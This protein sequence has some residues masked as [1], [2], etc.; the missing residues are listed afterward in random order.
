MSIF[1]IV[2]GQKPLADRSIPPHSGAQPAPHQDQP[3]STDKANPLNG[4]DSGDLIDFGQNEATAHQAPA[5]TPD[6]IE[7]MLKSTG[8]PAD[9][10]LMHFE[11]DMKRS[12]PRGGS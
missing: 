11:Q 4:E 10:P 12:L 8:K 3:S 5:K 9:G 2:E 6:E 7:K 1:P